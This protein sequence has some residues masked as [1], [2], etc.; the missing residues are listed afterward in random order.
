[1]GPPLHGAKEG[2]L[3]QVYSNCCGGSDGIWPFFYGLLDLP[4]E[5]LQL[6]KLL[7]LIPFSL[8]CF[9]QGCVLDMGCVK[10]QTSF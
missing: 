1:M 8:T 6:L 3:L 4:P 10:R 2:T 5:P 9:A 7:S